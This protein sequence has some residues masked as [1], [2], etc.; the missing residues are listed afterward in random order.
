M[1][2][3]IGIKAEPTETE[4]ALAIQ[5]NPLP[6]PPKFPPM[7]VISAVGVV[8]AVVMAYSVFRSS[9]LADPAG[10]HTRRIPIT[11]VTAVSVLVIVGWGRL[12]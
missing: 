12:P 2:A 1:M 11:L 8:L 4:N 6:A 7:S 5:A 3:P 10:H 9:R